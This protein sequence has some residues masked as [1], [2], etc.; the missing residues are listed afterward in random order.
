[1]IVECASI[2]QVFATRCWARDGS[3]LTVVLNI[4]VKGMDCKDIGI[5]LKQKGD[6][7]NVQSSIR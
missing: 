7:D 3:A 2:Y 4:F 5:T 1:M 6:H